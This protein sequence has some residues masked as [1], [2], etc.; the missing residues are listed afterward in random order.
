MLSG[1]GNNNVVIIFIRLVLIAALLINQRH[2]TL[3]VVLMY[4]RRES[5]PKASKWAVGFISRL[6]IGDLFLIDS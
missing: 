1:N 2:F 4:S 3:E 5:A 6:T